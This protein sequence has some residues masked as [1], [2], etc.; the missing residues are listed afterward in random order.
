MAHICLG[1]LLPPARKRWLHFLGGERSSVPNIKLK[2]QLS[3]DPPRPQHDTVAG[4]DHRD[5]GELLVIRM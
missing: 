1:G 4:S 3:S 2:N 5:L